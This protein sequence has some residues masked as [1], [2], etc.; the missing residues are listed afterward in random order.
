[1]LLFVVLF[2]S[3]MKTR[4][5]LFTILFFV[6]SCGNTGKGKQS[7]EP[8]ILKG[9]FI[10]NTVEGTDELQCYVFTDQPTFSQICGM[11]TTMSDK[12]DIPD[13]NK[14]IVVAVT[15]KSTNHPT[16]INLV[17]TSRENGTLIVSVAVD[18]SEDEL[19]YTLRP[20][21]VASFDKAGVKK[22]VFRKGGQD[23]Y[24]VDL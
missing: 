20:L 21:T 24:S 7:V 23:I 5:F 22:V 2:I 13:F 19:S 11:A 9:Y 16:S 12:P 1:M 4:F 6:A 18:A 3:F 15:G 17:K 8:R 10:K 14:S